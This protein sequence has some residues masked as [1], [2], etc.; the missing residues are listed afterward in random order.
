MDVS[1]AGIEVPIDKS[2]HLLQKIRKQQ[3]CNNGSETTITPFRIVM[4]PSKEYGEATPETILNSS[5]SS[6]STSSSH[7]NHETSTASSLDES[8]ACWEDPSRTPQRR[9]PQQHSKK[10]SSPSSSK[11]NSPNKNPQVKQSAAIITTTTTTADQLPEKQT[12]VPEESEQATAPVVLYDTERGG[13]AL[14]NAIAESDWD[15]ARH[16]LEMLPEQARTWV[17]STGTVQTTFDWSIWKRLPL[18][19]ASRRQA[20]ID[21][22][23]KLIQE[24]PQAIYQKTHFQQLPLHLAV[25]SNASADVVHLFLA[26]YFQ[27]IREPDQS[28]RTPM[29]ILESVEIIDDF[30][31]HALVQKAL[32]AAQRTYELFQQEKETALQELEQVHQNGLEALRVQHDEDL[33]AEQNTQEFIL[34]EVEAL[35][36]QLAQMRTRM[37]ETETAWNHVA[38]QNRMLQEQIEM[39]QK[40]SEDWQRQ[41]LVQKQIV[42]RTQQ[43]LQTQ[44]K[45]NQQLQQ[46]IQQYQFV[47]AEYGNIQEHTVVPQVKA[48]QTVLHRAMTEMQN[49]VVALEEHE[50]SLEPPTMTTTTTATFHSPETSVTESVHNPPKTSSISVTAAPPD[51]EASVISAN[52]LSSSWNASR[53]EEEDDDDDVFQDVEDGEGDDDLDDSEVFIKATEAVSSSIIMKDLLR[54]SASTCTRQKKEDPSEAQQVNGHHQSKE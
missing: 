32:Q 39:V 13:T 12:T 21:L 7:N 44:Q 2:N 8:G 15:T 45:Q 4:S 16:V 37:S 52:Q 6:S 49:L 53:P 46:Q 22:V 50:T 26:R 34:E 28:G 23:T 3:K 42:Q 31:Q 47:I 40:Q 18:H 38:S 20:P 14:F 17:V 43:S 35:R 1:N 25:E 54:T 5:T 11:L 29:D 36:Q 10:K 19:E 48:W 9:H 33:Q 30:E 24:Y 41:Y 27:A 51:P